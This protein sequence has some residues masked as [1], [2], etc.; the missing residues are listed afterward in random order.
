MRDNGSYKPIVRESLSSM[1][2]LADAALS[3]NKRP[4]IGLFIEHLRVPEE[5]NFAGKSRSGVGIGFG[6]LVDGK[7]KLRVGLGE[8]KG[9]ILHENKTGFTAEEILRKEAETFPSL[10]E[11]LALVSLHEVIQEGRAIE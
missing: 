11:N 4:A 1:H 9:L 10:R 6:E 8:A 2:I 3:G 7:F 5:A